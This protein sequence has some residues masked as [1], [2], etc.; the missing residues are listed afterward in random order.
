MTRY[1]AL[2]RAVNVGGLTVRMTDLKALCEAAGFSDVRTYIASGNV[3]FDSD[4]PPA[5]IKEAIEAGLKDLVGKPV[6]LFLRTGPE[7]A[8][9]AAANPF[10]D[11]NP[12]RVMAVFLDATPSP[13]ALA[14]K[15]MHQTIEQIAPGDRVVYVHYPDGMGRSKLK[16]R[17]LEPGTA[18]NMNTVAKLAELAGG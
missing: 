10:A 16:V 4:Q 18:R 6:P 12:S 13:A 9:V 15:V 17:A 2:L 8:A 1:A 14:E 7:L 11:A 5:R 3:V